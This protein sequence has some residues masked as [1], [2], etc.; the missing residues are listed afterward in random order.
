MSTITKALTA[1]QLASKLIKHA[2]H[3]ES[4]TIDANTGQVAPTNYWAVGGMIQAFGEFGSL[5]YSPTGIPDAD[6]LERQLRD[7]WD[8]IQIVGHLGLWLD[9][10]DAFIDSVYR[11]PCGCDTEGG[12]SDASFALAT[13]L[14]ISNGQDSICHVCETLDDPNCFPT[15]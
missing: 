12:F 13:Q 8:R 10:G 5:H 4:V 7:N 2:K 14:G 6:A 9:N 15:K 3:Q 1:K 11:I